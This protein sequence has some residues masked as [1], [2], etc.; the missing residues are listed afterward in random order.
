MSVARVTEITSASSKG[1]DDAVAKGI[2]RANKTLKNVRGAW[3]KEQKVTVEKGKVSRVSCH[4]EGDVRPDGLTSV[5][6]TLAAAATGIALAASAG[7]RAFLPLFA[8]GAAARW[9]HWP[10]ASVGRVA[11]ER[12]GAASSSGLASVVEVL[13]DKV[14]AVDHAARPAADR[15]EPD[16]GSRRRARGACGLA[17]AVR[18]RAR[19]HRRRTGGGRA[20]TPSA[21]SPG[22]RVRPTTGGAA[23]PVLSDPGGRACA[24]II[25]LA[26][27]APLIVLLILAWFV[28]RW[29]QRRRTVS[30][31]P[32]ESHVPPRVPGR[33][34]V[35]HC[36]STPGSRLSARGFEPWLEIDAAA[37][38]RMSRPCRGWLVDGRSSRWSRTMRTGSDSRSPDRSSTGCRRCTPSPSCEPPRRGHS[39]ARGCGSRS[40]SCRGST[41]GSGSS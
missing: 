24:V 29:L 23:N 39:G 32:H 30:G 41:T 22:S 38:R 37:V 8:A 1:F 33:R 3:I 34:I 5:V 6:E 28:C 9:F 18:A 15:A 4:H 14:P 35:A 27:L 17:G 11:L 25:V 36:R 16:R 12:R 21:H 19:D 31:V 10:L 40:C 2:D 26:F 20:S 7:L 13:A